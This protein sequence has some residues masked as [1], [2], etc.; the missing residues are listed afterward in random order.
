MSRHC[1]AKEPLAWWLNKGW[2]KLDITNPP[3]V[4][5]V[6]VYSEELKATG[7]R[8]LQEHEK[9]LRTFDPQSPAAFA[10]YILQSN[11]VVL[12]KDYIPNE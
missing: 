11:Y 9:W 10:R 1:P 2:K 5:F 12:I 6:V 7:S 8:N 3:A 4:D